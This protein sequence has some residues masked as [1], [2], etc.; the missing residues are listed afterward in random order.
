[1]VEATAS[2]SSDMR[3]LLIGID[4]YTSGV[5]AL[6][7]CVNDIDAMQRLFVDTLGVPRDRLQR[8]ASPHPGTAHETDVPELPATRDNLVRALTRLGDEDITSDQRVFIYFSGHGTA[9]PVSDAKG[10]NVLRGALVPVDAAVED[11]AARGL[12]YDLEVNRLLK[13]ITA[14]TQQVTFVL[15]C[16]HSGGATRDLGGA[17]GDA[18]RSVQFARAVDAAELAVADAKRSTGSVAAGTVDDCQVVAAC[19]ADEKAL[20]CVDEQGNKHG[21]L[22]QTLVKVLRAI[23][24]AE[25]PGLTW[26]RV[27]RQVVAGMESRKT[28]HPTLTG[29]FA[30]PLFGGPPRVGDMGYGVTRSGDVYTLDAGE[31][32]DVTEGALVAVYGA[33]PAVFPPIASPEDVAARVGAVRVKTAKRSSATAVA[34][35]APFDLPQGARARVVEAGAKA[36]L[37]VSIPSG[38]PGLV[39]Q[40]ASSG[41]TRVAAEGEASV[42]QLVRDAR[43]AL[44]LTDELHG[45]DEPYLVKI[46]EDKLG[47]VGALLDH[48]ARYHAPIR[49]SGMCTD[50]P[51]A[52]E[53]EVLDCN[54]KVDD[55]GMYQ[56]DAQSPELAPLT[57][58]SDGV[59]ELHDGDQV[60]FRLSNTSKTRLRVTLFDCA[61]DGYAAVLDDVVLGG[62]S[63][64]TFWLNDEL[65]RALPMSVQAGRSV[66]LDRIVVVGTNAV[67]KS[68]RHMDMSP[69]DTFEAVLEARAVGAASGKYPPP[70]R[71]TST[72]M[73]LRTRAQ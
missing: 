18:P 2:R 48:Y 11:G 57:R 30:R 17:P 27:W 43:G 73:T 1:M 5:P 60:C 36:R 19:L 38:E 70:E 39:A 50:L 13:R 72:R 47:K 26:G 12:L 55:N 61:P 34:E 63:S 9:V 68:L 52:L 22:S 16:C 54:G 49:M 62:Q 29:S 45:V 53:L 28:Q 35:G 3:V 20:E 21:L 64:H 14:R 8:V 4:A 65:G 25:L 24:P 66:S 40:V 56:G 6:N 67:E 59:Y 37:P 31:L 23:D 69:D 42:V 46:P 58:G 44:T 51:G 41:R 71:W 32:S 10:T 15:D 33:S 7:G